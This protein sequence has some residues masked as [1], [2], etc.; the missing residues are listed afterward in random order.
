MLT[1]SKIN[2]AKYYL[3]QCQSSAQLF[4]R[5]Q[6]GEPMGVWLG[7]AVSRLGLPETVKEKHLRSLLDGKDLYGE[8]LVKEHPNRISGWDLVVAAPKSVSLLWAIAPEK[9]Q[10]QIEELHLQSVAKAM[11]WM[12]SQLQ[13]RRAADGTDRQSVVV[14]IAAFGHCTNQD[15][16]PHLHHHCVVPNVGLGY[17]FT[18]AIDSTTLYRYQK[19]AGALYRA[20]FASTLA[21]ELG[22]SIQRTDQ[23]FEIVPFS[24]EQGIYQSLITTLSSRRVAIEQQQPKDSSEAARISK[25]TR[26]P[27]KEL[28]SRQE[29]FNQT[30]LLA[31]RYGLTQNAIK[32]LMRPGR[33]FGWVRT[34][35]N[36]WKCLREARTNVVRFQSH[37]S[38]RD[39]VCLL[40]QAAQ[41]R[42]I[43]AN[44][45]LELAEKVISSRYIRSLGQHRGEQR[46]TTH[47]I[48][49]QEQ[50]LMRS[51]SNI[52]N[53]S[54]MLVRSRIVDDSIQRYGLSE[55]QA[56]CLK[57]LCQSPNG[58]KILTG[59]SGTGK[60]Q[61]VAALSD[62]LA[63]G[64]YQVVTVSPSAQSLSDRISHPQS[65][66]SSLLDTTAQNLTVGQILWRLEKG[67][68]SLSRSS[69]VV[70]DDANRM[71][72]TQVSNLTAAVERS[73]AKLILSGDLHVPQFSGAF[74]AIARTQKPIELKQLHR[75]VQERD[76]AF[77]REIADGKTMKALK[78]LL[79]RN[80]LTLHSSRREAIHTIV[81]QWAQNA[82]QDFRNHQI[83]V[84]SRLLAHEVN[85]TAQATLKQHGLLQGTP[86]SVGSILL[87]VGDR[88]QFQQHHRL[89][90]ICK[91]DTATVLKLSK[92]MRTATV[93]LD[94]GA[95]RVISLQPT[96]NVKLGYA[97]QSA[98]LGTRV[99]AQAYVLTEGVCREQT[100]AQISQFSSRMHLHSWQTGSSILRE[101]ARLMQVERDYQLAVEIEQT[102]TQ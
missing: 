85:Q 48:Y 83:I 72:L 99:P 57:H 89:D 58:L 69:A 73:G 33:K 56:Q 101:L 44:R 37:F 91:G 42:G 71:S 41:G 52:Q 98:Q 17:G 66:L 96:Q 87:Y 22:L 36:E 16:Q 20:E 50:S 7:S 46:F 95:R 74:Q 9:I 75:Q 31:E 40:A 13:S 80:Q 67:Q 94:N 26:S 90:G 53:R 93:Q 64:G 35:W 68:F 43:S 76:R 8:R 32:R 18:G 34:Q 49:K 14:A 65:F 45:V 15:R 47:R 70:V 59:L 39:L 62:S 29:V 86:L 38:K 84:D 54:P 102:R 81:Q 10:V 79:E 88:I 60:T 92:L 25:A 28:R 97:V 55:E 61:V 12:E 6:P 5:T 3:R 100:L 27:D 1:V 77:I 78:D 21:A 30:R 2:N 51:I 4:D 82:P 63:R 24:R 11:K 19:A 23:S